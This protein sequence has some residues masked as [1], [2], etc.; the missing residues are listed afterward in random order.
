MLVVALLAACASTTKKPDPH[1]VYVPFGVGQ[2][3]NGERVK[4]TA[5]AI[6]ESAAVTTSAG[7]WLYLRLKYPQDLVPLDEGPN[8][9]TLQKVQIVAGVTFFA[10]YAL[11]VI[12]ALVNYRVRTRGISPAIISGSPG[13]SWSWS[14]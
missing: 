13:L 14:R 11:G 7:V 2:F 5:L 8:V 10:T 4:G 9:R 6:V 1:Y 3:Q 12:D